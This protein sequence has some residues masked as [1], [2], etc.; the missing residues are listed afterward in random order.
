MLETQ[1]AACD[2]SLLARSA[3]WCAGNVAHLLSQH[4][5]GCQQQ[6]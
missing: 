3:E 2:I 6:E 4:E 5:D 1:P